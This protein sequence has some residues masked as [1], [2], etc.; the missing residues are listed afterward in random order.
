LNQ[1]ENFNFNTNKP[2][3]VNFN[4]DSGVS[5]S[6]GSSKSGQGISFDD[7]AAPIK[8][9]F[10]SESEFDA[11]FDFKYGGSCRKYVLYASTAYWDGHPEIISQRGVIYIYSDWKQDADGNYIAGFKVGDGNAYLSDMPFVNGSDSIISE[12]SEYW[13]EHSSTMS[14]A[15]M[16]YIY[17][18]LEPPKFKIGDGKAY[19]GD[20]PF[21]DED[22]EDHIRDQIR[23]ITQQEREFW[24][25]KVRATDEG[26]DP[27]ELIFTIH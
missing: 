4:S 6:F 12:T 20:L 22:W 2:L 25:N 27:E 17:N 19:I 13:A 10:S 16:I 26:A 5:V 9:D 24:N 1:N 14:E 8:I 23:H 11:S 15:G 18:D 3:D 21:Y 7:V